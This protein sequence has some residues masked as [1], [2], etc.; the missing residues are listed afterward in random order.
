DKV[1]AVD[2]ID[3]VIDKAVSSVLNN[4]QKNDDLGLENK[5]CDDN[6]GKDD[7]GCTDKQESDDGAH[8]K[9]VDD[10]V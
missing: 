9:I 1:D 4:P 10:P 2:D 5:K 7:L 8:N 6:L 3:E